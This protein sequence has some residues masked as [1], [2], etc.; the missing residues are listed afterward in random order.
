ME[1]ETCPDC[2]N[3]NLACLNL[4]HRRNCEISMHDMLT[5]AFAEFDDAVLVQ[6][7][8][9]VVTVVEFWGLQNVVIQRQ[10]GVND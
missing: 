10:K 1:F 6:C 7:L 5:K 3:Q 9:D 4:A 2:Q 8:A